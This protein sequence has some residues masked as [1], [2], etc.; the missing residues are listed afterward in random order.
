MEITQ[1]EIKFILKT[2]W[3]YPITP[4]EE[5]DYNILHNKLLNELYTREETT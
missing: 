2:M 1:S 5:I 3:Q 4:V